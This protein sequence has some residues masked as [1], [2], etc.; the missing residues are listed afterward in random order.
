MFEA[1]SAAVCEKNGGWM[2][3]HTHKLTTITLPAHV[4]VRVNNWT[5]YIEGRFNKHAKSLPSLGLSLLVSQVVL[6]LYN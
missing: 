5:S 6:L 2:D 4:Q 3:R 1:W